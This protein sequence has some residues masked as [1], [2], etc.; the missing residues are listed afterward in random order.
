MRR[1]ANQILIFV[2][3]PPLVRHYCENSAIVDENRQ[4]R[5]RFSKS[6]SFSADESVRRT[7][8]LWNARDPDE[9]DGI[10]RS[11]P[12]YP[13]MTA[14]TTQLSPHPSDPATLA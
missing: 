8:G 7:L 9:L 5:C 3:D 2:A 14:T 4:R 13:W 11:L 10:M 6:V 12:L 1:S